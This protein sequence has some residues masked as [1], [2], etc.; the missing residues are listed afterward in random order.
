M[1]SN[2][3]PKN[4]EPVTGVA[5]KTTYETGKNGFCY[6]A[7]CVRLQTGKA[8]PICWYCSSNNFYSEV[9]AECANACS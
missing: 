4:D 6:A 5:A 3:V 8:A 7:V 1:I 9:K 2:V